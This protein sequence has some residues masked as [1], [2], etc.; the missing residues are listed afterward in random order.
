MNP[1]IRL[2]NRNLT[3][4]LNMGFVIWQIV[5]PLIYIF[6]AGF[7]YT[8]LIHQVPFGGRTLDYPAFIATGMIGFNIMNSTLIS[9]IIIWND[10]RHGM[11]EQILVGPFTRAQ[12]ILSNVY[13]IGIIGLV[14][15]AMITAVG[16]P[17]FF[18]QAQF[19]VLTIPLVVF[20]SITGSILFGS[21]ASIISTRL[22]S[23]EGFNVVI[24][25][26]FL[27]FAFVSTAFY[28]AQGAPP[29]LSSAFYLNPLTYLVDVVRA[30]IFGYFDGMVAQ[31]M[32]ILGVGAA[33]L[34][35]VATKML[36][37]LEL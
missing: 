13:T 27:F 7:A 22:K 17:L 8:A 30:G 26:A 1:I 11:F 23:S 9:G 5:F 4:S 12:Y 18:K 29:I 10:R 24:N 14:S 25:T 34:F 20:A 3:I 28:P 35:V 16:Y 6:V 36:S 15:A 21:I 31:E 32:I 33:I 37:K 2:V 19:N